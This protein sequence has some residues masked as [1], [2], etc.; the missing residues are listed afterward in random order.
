ML[1]FISVMIIMDVLSENSNHK[2]KLREDSTDIHEGKENSH[3]SQFLL[4]VQIAFATVV[5]LPQ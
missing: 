3:T 4:L 1:L 2:R 5:A